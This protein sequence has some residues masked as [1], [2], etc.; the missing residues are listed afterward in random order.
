[1]RSPEEIADS[2]IAE[3]DIEGERLDP[4][5]VLAVLAE[6]IRE[7]QTAPD[8]KPAGEYDYYRKQYEK[9]TGGI[10]GLSLK[11]EG[12]G[13]HRTHWLSVSDDQARRILA[14]LSTESE[15]K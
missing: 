10:D 6:G 12:E 11:I 7:A 4:S 2:V 15:T 8:F 5:Q 14:M 13:S 1:M 3:Y 9:I